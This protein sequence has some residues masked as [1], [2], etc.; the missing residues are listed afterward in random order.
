VLGIDESIV[1]SLSLHMELD[2][3]LYIMIKMDIDTDMLAQILA[4]IKSEEVMM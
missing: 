1:K 4:A 3:P 2:E